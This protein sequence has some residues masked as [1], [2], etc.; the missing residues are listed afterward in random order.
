VQINM[1]GY[2]Q[3]SMKVIAVL[4]LD[5]RCKDWSLDHCKDPFIIGDSERKITRENLQI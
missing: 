2:A 1:L 3:G 5:I 4:S